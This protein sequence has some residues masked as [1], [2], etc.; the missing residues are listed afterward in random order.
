MADPKST[1]VKSSHTLSLQWKPDVPRD[2]DFSLPIPLSPLHMLVLQATH[3]ELVTLVPANKIA[4]R[5]PQ[6]GAHERI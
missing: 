5:S 1:A 3:V 4:P 6:S 2:N